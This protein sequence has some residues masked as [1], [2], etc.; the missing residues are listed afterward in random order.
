[1][2]GFFSLYVVIDSITDDV[3]TL[4]FEPPISPGLIEPVELYLKIN[5]KLIDSTSKQKK[6][7]FILLG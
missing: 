1:M 6:F 3:A 7:H 4:G 2:F 5:L